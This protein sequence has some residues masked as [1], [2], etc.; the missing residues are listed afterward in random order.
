MNELYEN[1][2]RITIILDERKYDTLTHTACHNLNLNLEKKQKKEIRR[3]G[4]VSHDICEAIDKS[5]IITTKELFKDVKSDMKTYL[6]RHQVFCTHD[7]AK[8]TKIAAT[9]E[10]RLFFF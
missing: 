5:C 7:R 6:I 3:N 9:K 4:Y 8:S 1:S 2:F 10:G